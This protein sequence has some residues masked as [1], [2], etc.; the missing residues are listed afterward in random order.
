MGERCEWGWSGIDLI[1]IQARTRENSRNILYER[2]SESSV[3]INFG[4][5]DE[6]LA[7]FGPHRRQDTTAHEHTSS[8]FSSRNALS[9]PSTCHRRATAG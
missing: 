1:I 6:L 3:Q 8:P 4:P 9:L 7:E 2:A 5:L